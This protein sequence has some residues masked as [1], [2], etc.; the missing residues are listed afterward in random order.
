M[1]NRGRVLRDDQPLNFLLPAFYLSEATDSAIARVTKGGREIRVLYNCVSFRNGIQRGSY[2]YKRCIY[3][4]YAITL[5]RIRI[6]DLI[7]LNVGS[8]PVGFLIRP[9]VVVRRL[10]HE[11][12][13]TSV[14]LRWRKKNYSVFN[15]D[16]ALFTKMRPLLNIPHNCR[17]MAYNLSGLRFDFANVMFA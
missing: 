6:M 5:R 17:V 3:C 10:T 8:L 12:R 11:Y 2:R 16:Y 13:I 9:R 15:K 7:R 1:P 4:V 14:N